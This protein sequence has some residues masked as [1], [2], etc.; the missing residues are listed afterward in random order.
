M[1]KQQFKIGPSSTIN[2]EKCAGS[3]SLRGSSKAAFSVSSDGKVQVTEDT[4]K[5]GTTL[6]VSAASGFKAYIPNDADIQIGMVTGRLSVKDCYRLSV[7][8][9]AG[10]D[11][12]SGVRAGID[13]GRVAG[14]LEVRESGSVVAHTV[15]G[16]VSAKEING[17]IR[18]L[19]V[20]DD[21][22]VRGCSGKIEISQIQGDA[23]L[24]KNTGVIKLDSVG[25]DVILQ[26][27]LLAEKHH[28]ISAGD[29]IVYWPNKRSVQFLVTH[30]GMLID[31]MHL[32]NETNIPGEFKATIGDDSCRLII[33]AQGNVYLRPEHVEKEKS[34]SKPKSESK[35]K[36]DDDDFDFDFDLEDL[37]DPEELLEKIGDGLKSMV[38]LQKRKKGKGLLNKIFG[39]VSRSVDEWVAESDEQ[40]PAEKQPGKAQT[41]GKQAVFDSEEERRIVLKL[42]DAGSITV[43][44]AAERLKNLS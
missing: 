1:S 25:G 40:I 41:A 34:K 39:K 43:D 28:I 35:K 42:L 20:M 26:G 18:I 2:I 17:D 19:N 36:D 4:S 12:I 9:S 22:S 31:D 3:L 10:D 6:N 14:D 24:N 23:F 15:Q 30:K 8:Q 38:M 13:L 29:V 44:E 27:P 11:K 33:E 32:M 5:A 37:L 21:F 16:D 7:D